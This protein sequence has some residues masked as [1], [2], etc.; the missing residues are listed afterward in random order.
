MRTFDAKIKNGQ[1]SFYE[2]DTEKWNKFK[3]FNEGKRIH[4]SLIEEESMRRRRMFE[5]AVVPL[6][7]FFQEHYDHRNNEHRKLVRSWLQE[8][9]C[10]EI[11]EV[12]GITKKV[13]GS[14]KNKLGGEDQLVETVKNYMAENYGINPDLVLNTKHYEDWR[15]TIYPFDL[16]GP[17]NYID[18]LVSIH[19]LNPKESYKKI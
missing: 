17:D 6:L 10:P 7:T 3:K 15:D 13:G 12:N 2:G 1:V 18:Y 9:F 4:I 14:T 19:R 16:G 11:V 8:E 5:G